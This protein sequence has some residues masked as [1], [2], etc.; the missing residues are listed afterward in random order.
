MPAPAFDFLFSRFPES[1]YEPTPMAFDVFENAECSSR[2]E[3]HSARTGAMSE[4]TVCHNQ[5]LDKE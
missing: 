4:Q 2:I 1:A 5:E 3:L